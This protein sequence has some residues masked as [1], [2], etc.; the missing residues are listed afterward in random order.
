MALAKWVFCLAGIT[1]VLMVIPPYS[2][3]EQLGRDNPPPINHPEFYYGFCG[4]TLSWQLL[5]LV[6]GR[7]PMRYRQAMIPAMVEKASFVIAILILYALE[8]VAVTWLA[9]AALDAVWL[10]LFF[11]AYVQAVKQPLP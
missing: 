7:D 10:V 1:G 4:V 5:F 3:E 9:F 8:R 2:L 11:I 6:I